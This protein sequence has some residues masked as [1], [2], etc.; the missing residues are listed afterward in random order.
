MLNWLKKILHREQT[1]K[2]EKII[3]GIISFVYVF[4]LG[5]A[6]NI[7]TPERRAFYDSLIK[8]EIT[9]DDTVFTIVWLALFIMIA[10]SGYFAWNHYKDEKFRKI[11]IGL[12]AINGFLIYLWPNVFFAQQ[13]ITTALYL[14]IGMIVIA[15]LM[16]LAAFRVNQKSAYLL[17]PYLGWLFFATYLNTAFVVLNG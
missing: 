4:S 5:Y 10:W 15:E 8:P 3:S 11:F 1:T 2:K 9:P 17:I 7:W 16:I 13:N 12:F 6:G 14:I